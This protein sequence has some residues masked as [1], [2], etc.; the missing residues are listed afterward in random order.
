MAMKMEKLGMMATCGAVHT[1][2]ATATKGIE[3]ERTF[4]VRLYCGKSE[5]DIA[6]R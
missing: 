2:V 5:S 3:F 4:R 6:S 1:V